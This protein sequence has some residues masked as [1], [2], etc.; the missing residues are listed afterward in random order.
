[1]KNLVTHKTLCTSNRASGRYVHG[2]SHSIS[3][4]VSARIEIIKKKKKKKK[5]AIKSWVNWKKKKKLNDKANTFST[6]G[7]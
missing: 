6:M 2:W 4:H 7:H 5:V 3:S 1:M